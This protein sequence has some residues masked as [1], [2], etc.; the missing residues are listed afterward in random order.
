MSRFREPP[1]PVFQRLNASLGFDRRLAP[2]DIAQS[3]AHVAMLAETGVLTGEEASTLVRGLDEV[4]GELER[5]DSPSTTATKTS[6]WR[7]SGA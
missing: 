4:G 5:G 2:Y 3:Q 6:T 1:D 7:S